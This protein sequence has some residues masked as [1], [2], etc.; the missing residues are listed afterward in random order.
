[1]GYSWIA[2]QQDAHE[3]NDDEQEGLRQLRDRH[4]KA[5]GKENPDLPDSIFCDHFDLIFRITSKIL[6]RQKRTRQIWIRLIE[7]SSAEVSG[8]SEVPRID[9]KLIS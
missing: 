6:P 9:G 8:P 2:D 3:K 7:Y 1:M 4:W 5:L